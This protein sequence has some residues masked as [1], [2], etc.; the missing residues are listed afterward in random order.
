MRISMGA[1]DGDFAAALAG[2]ERS[3]AEGLHQAHCGGCNGDGFEGHAGTWA[4]AVRLH[5][6][7]RRQAA[8]HPQ[9][10]R[11]RHAGSLRAACSA[12]SSS[13]HLYQCAAACAHHQR[14]Q[15]HPDRCSEYE[16]SEAHVCQA[17]GAELPEKAPSR[18][19]GCH[20]GAAGQA[21]H[22]TGIYVRRRCSIRM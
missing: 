6:Q 19:A 1:S 22:P 14:S 8:A 17:A 13:E 12:C 18:D 11:I 20:S 10:R 21:P 5:H 2:V 4:D 3:D 16:S 9:L 15:H 7:G